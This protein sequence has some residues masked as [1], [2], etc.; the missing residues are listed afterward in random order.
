MDAITF[1]NLIHLAILEGLE[2]HL[3]NV[4]T[5]YLYGTIDSDIYMKIP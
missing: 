2:M 4:A 3:I 5:A 1:R